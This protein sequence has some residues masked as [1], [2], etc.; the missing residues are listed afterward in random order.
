MWWN[1]N[2]ENA[3][4]FTKDFALGDHIIELYGIENG[5]DGKNAAR[6]AR[7]YSDF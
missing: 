7:G 4:R 2:W 3:Y 5:G 6:F 1:N